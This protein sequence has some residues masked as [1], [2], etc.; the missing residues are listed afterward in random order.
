MQPRV[1][2]A[3]LLRRANRGVHARAAAVDPGR[4]GGAQQGGGAR[5]EFGRRGG[6][7]TRAPGNPPSS[8]AEQ[9]LEPAVDQV[10][11]AGTLTSTA[12]LAKVLKAAVRPAAAR[13]E[14]SS[15]RAAAHGDRLEEQSMSGPLEGLA[16]GVAEGICRGVLVG[17]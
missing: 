4:A 9:R 14:R 3:A 7:A 5:G 16:G 15:C 13:G 6:A 8:S 10:V 2:L 17:E 11:R 1:A 12:E